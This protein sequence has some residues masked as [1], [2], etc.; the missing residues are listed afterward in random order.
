M[1]S[2]SSRYVAAKVFPLALATAAGAFVYLWITKPAPKK[3]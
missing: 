2:R 1:A 3:S